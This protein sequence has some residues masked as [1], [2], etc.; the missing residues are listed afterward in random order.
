MRFS[1]SMRQFDESNT[2]KPERLKK[3]REAGDCILDNFMSWWLNPRSAEYKYLGAF[4]LSNKLFY[5]A[6][7]C[8]EYGLFEEAMITI[9]D[10]IDAA[11]FFAVN[12]IPSPNAGKF[13]T[14]LIPSGERNKDDSLKDNWD[15]IKQRAIELHILD[16]DEI[17][18]INKLRD[19]GNFSAHL[20]S[21]Q[22]KQLLKYSKK[23]VEGKSWKEITG[24]LERGPFISEGDS[25]KKLEEASKH[26]TLIRKRYFDH[27]IEPK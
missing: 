9:R 6:V 25:G 17:D 1:E 27:Y 18:R 15:Y 16:K 13:N 8:Y 21:R 7:R 11:L 22:G 19:I 2:L 3:R 10:A 5:E 26:L 24:E 20:A 4:S 14:D 12:Y 23:L